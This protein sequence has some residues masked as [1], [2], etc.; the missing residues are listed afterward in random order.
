MLTR[1]GPSLTD[2]QIAIV[3]HVRADK[4]NLIINALAGTGK[5]STLK[6][7][8]EASKKK[9]MLY[10]AFNRRVVD[11]V[12]DERKRAKAGEDVHPFPDDVAIRT[13]NGCGH[14]AWGGTIGKGQLKLDP[15]KTQVLL[16]EVTGEW[17]GDDRAFVRDSFWDIIK[18]VGLAKNLGYVPQGKFPSAKRLATKE[19][20]HASLEEKPGPLLADLV[21][22]LLFR[23]IKAAYEGWIDYDDQIYMPTLF[24]GTFPRFPHVLGDEVQDLN[25]V[26]HEMLKRLVTDRLSAVGD[27]YQSIYA[28]RGAVQSGMGDIQSKFSCTETALSTSFRCHEEIVK[29]AR[30][31]APEFKWLKPGGCY[32]KLRTVNSCAFPEGSAI[33]CRNN[34][35]LFSIAFRL[36]AGGRS[37]TVAGSEIGP[38]L[39]R[40][41]QKIGQEGDDS[42]TLI[43]KIDAWRNEKE[44]KSQQPA[45]LHD[46]A[47]CLKIFAG[48]GKDLAQAVAYAEFLFKQQGTIKLTTGHKAKGLEWDRTFFLDPWLLNGTEQDLNLRYVIQTRAKQTCYEI[49]SKDIRW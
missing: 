4:G 25:P 13:F 11:E 39:V 23:S 18:A 49:D 29:A 9:P 47:E 7:I 5:T 48:F 19:Q 35:P 8:A 31:R 33:I 43:A 41:L 27:K 20:F 24:G 38:K 22:T 37:V 10:L 34:A 30:W 2:E 44:E 42:E 17:K 15:K 40:L 28:F 26:N 36:L 3:D 14:R 1:S 21:D 12:E 6:L 46:Q 16:K 32:E 45:S